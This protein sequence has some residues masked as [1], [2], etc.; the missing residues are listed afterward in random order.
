MN[1]EIIVS[2]CC[3][4]YNHQKYIRDAIEGFL[5]QKTT[6]PFEI[7]IHDDASTDGTADIIREY[8]AKY[9]DII[10][11]IYQREN[12]YSKGIKISQV[13]Q[14]P[15]AQGKYIA[16]CEGDDYWIDPLKL[17]KQ[18]EFL[19]NK[20][21]ISIVIHPVKLEKNGKI[22]NERKFD[23]GKENRFFYSTDIIKE[24]GQFAATCSYVLREEVVKQL[25]SWSDRYPVGDF[26]LEMYSQKVG[27]GLYLP[28][29]M[30]VYRISTH[31][32][33]T[34]R[35]LAIPTQRKIFSINMMKYY[36]KL[37]EDFP[38]LTEA[39]FST[40]EIATILSICK[41]SLIIGDFNCFNQWVSIL[42]KKYSKYLQKKTSIVVFKNYPQ[43][44]HLYLKLRNKIVFIL[45][46]YNIK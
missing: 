20:K 5:M 2:I 10:K 9:P 32:S 27:K 33:W 42:E 30:G 45:K 28:D 17:Q 39:D 18:V 23:L 31:N 13:Y 46:K 12:Q 3:I 24:R 22:I 44:L 40:R 7:L 15:R 8:E 41:S 29:V 21:N 16:L 25:P 4:T 43:I 34:N 19:E 26:L 35:V 37:K 14:F 38:K 1:K 11:P 36:T 6:F